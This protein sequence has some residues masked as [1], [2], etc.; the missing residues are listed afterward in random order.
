MTFCHMIVRSW[1]VEEMQIPMW[2]ENLDLFIHSVVYT[3]A[4]KT[5]EQNFKT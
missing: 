4:S 5:K 3:V 2:Y 1:E